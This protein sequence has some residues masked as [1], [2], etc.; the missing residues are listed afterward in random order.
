[1]KQA[2]AGSAFNYSAAHA[3]YIA[4]AKQ[5]RLAD[6]NNPFKAYRIREKRPRPGD[7]VC[8][9]RAGSGATYDN[10]RVGHKTHCDIVTEVKP[11][12]LTSIG[13]NVSDSVKATTVTTDA[14]GYIDDS[15][16]FVVVTIEDPP[17]K[18]M[19]G[20]SYTPKGIFKAFT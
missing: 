19:T 13:G 18:H 15:K 14:A 10:I 5:N 1:M 11:G 4:A 17:G 3:A 2:G 20:M 16:Y 7:L 8:K 12:Q 6:N 9:S